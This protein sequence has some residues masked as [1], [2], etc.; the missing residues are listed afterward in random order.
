M[1]CDDYLQLDLVL[2]GRF[3]LFFRDGQGSEFKILLFFVDDS[4]L[5]FSF[6]YQATENSIFGC[7]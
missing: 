6:D 4:D 7:D 5:T 1:L 3:V 2:L